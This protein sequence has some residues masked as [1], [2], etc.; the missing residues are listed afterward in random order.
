MCERTSCS[1]YCYLL[2]VQKDIS[3]L[4]LWVHAPKWESVNLWRGIKTSA[5]TQK[6]K[7]GW[8][9]KSRDESAIEGWKWNQAPPSKQNLIYLSKLIIHEDQ[10]PEKQVECSLERAAKLK[11]LFWYHLTLLTSFFRRYSVSVNFEQCPRLNIKVC[12]CW[13][14]W[15]CFSRSFVNPQLAYSS[16]S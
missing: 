1:Q 4:R 9:A 3:W 11:V 10:R 14:S 6:L 16:A 8:K 7:R 15:I 13:N 12:L 5:Q 2:S